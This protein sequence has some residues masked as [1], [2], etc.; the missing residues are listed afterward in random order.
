MSEFDLVIRGGHAV[1][2]DGTGDFDIGI[3]GGRIAAIGS[4]LDGGEV[5]DASGKLVLPGGIDSHCHIDQFSSSGVVAV[6]DFHSGSRSAAAGGTTTIIPFAAQYP[7]DSLRDVVTKY[8]QRADGKS[9]IDYAF[10]LI[11]S[12]PTDQVLGQ[13]LPALIHDGY[14]SFKIFMTYDQLHLDDRQILDVLATARREGAMVMVHAENFDVIE[15]L[16]EKLVAAGNTAPKFHATAHAAVAEREATH[17]AISLAEIVG[18]PVLIVHVSGREAMEQIAW[19]RDKGLPVYGETCPQYLFLTADDMDRP[20]FEG[21]KYMC[22]PPPRDKESQEH[23][24]RGLEDGIF[25]V[26]SSDHAPYRFTGDA[27]KRVAGESAHFDKIPNGV[28]GLEIRLP[29]LYSAGVRTGR[30]SLER[31]VDLTSTKAAKLYGLYPKK[32][33]LAVGSDADIAIWDPELE[34]TVRQENLH[35]NMDYTPYEGSQ[36]NGWPVMTLSRGEVVWDGSKVTGMPGR[37]QFLPCDKPDPAQ[38]TGSGILDGI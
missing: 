14:T 7:G 15:W 25:D 9:I 22:S 34:V 23:V 13:E 35:D 28:P 27:G 29:M 10:H 1:T 37:G 8:H 20:G 5:I 31:F 32:G 18:V 36:V 2:A 38:S 3:T 12:D 26:F 21:A 16:T 24:W 19:A 30:L 4:G 33:V 6:D 17:R 11:I